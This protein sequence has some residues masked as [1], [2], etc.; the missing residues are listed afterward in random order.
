M[1]FDV[2]DDFERL[3]DFFA[4][5][6]HAM[7]GVPIPSNLV[8]MNDAQV[9]AIKF[10]RH[11]CS[12]R[13]AANPV[14]YVSRGLDSESYVDHSSVFVL[15]RAALETYL[16]F[17]HVYGQD[18][19]DVRRFRHLLWKYGGFADRQKMVPTT[20][21]GRRK[22]A[23]ER[24]SQAE[25]K[26]AIES[27]IR[28][29]ACDKQAQKRILNGEWRGGKSWVEIGVGAG[30][31]PQYIRNAYGYLCGY[32]HSSWLSILQISQTLEL[33]QQRRMVRGLMSMLV[34]ILSFF[35]ADHVR[36]FPNGAALLDADSRA[37][38][39]AARWRV[40]GEHMSPSYPADQGPPAAS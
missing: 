10:Y 29:K 28:W 24:V 31:H 27:H 8:W 30:F 22:I 3:L 26:A 9:L 17:A 32:S 37:A 35:V 36:L 20:E 19:P 16:T 38:A 7:A 11:L 21:Q 40:T 1:H 14:P 15:T 23:D 39:I 13:N 4:S 6:I 25:L 18:D 2:D 5:L 33:D 34:T 12:I